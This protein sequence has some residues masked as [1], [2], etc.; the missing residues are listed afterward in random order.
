MVGR[1]ISIS[2]IDGSGKSTQIARLRAVFEAA[3]ESVTVIWYRPGYSTRL[4]G[5]RRFVRRF[6]PEVLPTT[7]A[8]ERREAAFGRPAVRR[9]WI[10]TALID[11]LV[12]WGALVRWHLAR[13]RVVICDRYVVDA[14]IDFVLRFGSGSR[15]LRHLLRLIER[16]CPTP[17]TSLLLALPFDEM[18]RR[19]EDKEEPFPESLPNRR[20]RYEAYRDPK[21]RSGLTIIDGSGATN[22]V[23][24]RI[25][26]A[27]GIGSGN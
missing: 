7:D 5:V 12:E 2:G 6:V 15:T 14:K 18:L 3:G 8:P 20:I 9:A 25:C 19:V 16:A 11:S 23:H 26:D 13:G 24:Q 10:L 27:V 4:D 21:V 22:A 1:L 17:D